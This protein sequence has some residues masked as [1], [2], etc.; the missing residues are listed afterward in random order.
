MIGTPG[1]NTGGLGGGT[2][3]P[4]PIAQGSAAPA[5]HIDAAPSGAVSIPPLVVITMCMI[6]VLGGFVVMT[7]MVVVRLAEGKNR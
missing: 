4:T 6:I 5:Q 1:A 3:V 2:P 7:R